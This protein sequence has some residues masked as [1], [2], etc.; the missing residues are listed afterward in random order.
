[1][2][3]IKICG[4]TTVDDARA[5]AAAG[6]D[7]IGINFYAHSPR[8]V[9]L[10][11][12]QH[13]AAVIPRGV[14][15]VGLFVNAPAEAVCG[16]FDA[17]GLDL[18]QL[19]GDEP[20]EFLAGLGARPVMRAF[21]VGSEGVKPVAAYLE[22]CREL[23]TLPALALVDARR[24]GQYGGTGQTADWD[25]L[26]N[27]RAMLGD[28]PLVLAGGL[29]PENVATAIYR[30]RPTAVDTASGVETKPGHKDADAVR[31]FVAAAREAFANVGQDDQWDT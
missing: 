5:V 28:V 18:I 23:G 4:V 31:R 10:E 3:T 9:P 8:F 19:H 29:T 16:A 22:R 12:A 20:P 7:A 15:R 24:P 25:A 27:E 21:R 17:L 14:V 13:V 6:A 1:M 11:R 26:A 30:V 2:F